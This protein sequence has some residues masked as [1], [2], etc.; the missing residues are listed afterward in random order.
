MKVNNWTLRL[1]AMGVISLPS[2]AMADEALSPVMSAVQSTTLSGY[3]SA[4]AIW[5]TGSNSTGSSYGDYSAYNGMGKGPN[6]VV[7]RSF[8]GQEKQD[9]FNLDVVSLVLEKPLDES[10]WAAGYRVQL[11]LGPDASTLNTL[12]P[13]SDLST[14]DLAIKNAYVA[15]KAPVGN[16]LDFKV[17]VWDTVVGYE[18]ADSPANPNY[19]RSFGFY[20][21]PITHTG[22][23]ASYQFTDWLSAQA[24]IANGLGNPKNN[25]AVGSAQMI[26]SRAGTFEQLSYLG[27][28][29]LTAPESMG[30]LKGATLYGGIVQTG[31]AYYDDPVNFYAGLALPTPIDKLSLGLSYDYRSNGVFED[32]YENAT[33]LYVSLQLT[34]KL[35]LN[36]RGDY[37]TG[38]HGAYGVKSYE[39]NKRSKTELLGVTGTIDYALWPNAITR[40]EARWDHDLTGNGVFLDGAT[41]NGISRGAENAISLALNV[42][43]KF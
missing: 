36:L 33:G 20:I 32:S 41:E 42:I 21:E 43:Y 34:E 38:S 17:G 10:Q 4:S 27:S 16:G 26:N 1:A 13:S 18:V 31:V 6:Y 24:G 39:N 28:V 15:L 9:G 30:F 2:V 14:G 11:W 12:S 5:L 19:S 29:A 22:I 35:R 8:D 37:A 3:V 23:L 25:Y 7:G 40:L